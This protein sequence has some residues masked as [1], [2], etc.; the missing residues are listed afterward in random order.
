MKYAGDTGNSDV[1][2]KDGTLNVKGDTKLISTSADATGIKVTAKVGDNITTNADGKAVA[3]T[4]NGIATTDNVTQA[5]NNS[6][7]KV[8]SLNNGGTTNGTTSE[9]VSPGDTV[10]FSAGKNIVLDLSLIH[11]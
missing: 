8:T 2:L 7:W 1:L 10:T 9:K 6:G 11:I 3:P 4:T 5:I